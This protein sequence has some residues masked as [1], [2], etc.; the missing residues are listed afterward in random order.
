M[1]DPKRPISHRYRQFRCQDMLWEVFEEMASDHERPVDELIDEAMRTYAKKQG[2]GVPPSP[3]APSEGIKTPV[4]V[5]PPSIPQA[6]P[7][8][9]VSVPGS[10]STAP[11]AGPLGP[12]YLTFGDATMLIDREQF[13]IGR[14]AKHADLAIEDPDVSRRH[15]AIIRRPNGYYIRDLSST[16]GITFK[17][18]RIDHRRIED[19]DVFHICSHEIRFK[20]RG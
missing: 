4:R 6:P 17:G 8:A 1:S 10:Y 9:A 19:G 20:Y 15:A 3:S 13:V 12:L 18:T 5:T 7:A 2:Y 14:G 11:P 16:N